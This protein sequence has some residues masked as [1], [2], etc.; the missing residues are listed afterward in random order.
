M[1]K[2]IFIETNL[3]FKSLIFSILFLVFLVVSVYLKSIYSYVVLDILMYII[4]IF[5]A[6]WFLTIYSLYKSRIEIDSFGL[7]A[8]YY[9]WYEGFKLDQNETPF[10][11]TILWDQIEN[12]SHHKTYDTTRDK[13][14][15][16][17]RVILKGKY[18]LCIVLEDYQDDKVQYILKLIESYR[19]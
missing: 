10:V 4:I 12:V 9:I 6:L 13:K 8:L 5:N 11:K 2:E 7:H 16:Y 15:D 18:S 1:K 14:I 19:Y 3:D 17:I